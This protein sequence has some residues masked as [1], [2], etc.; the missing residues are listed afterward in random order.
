MSTESGTVKVTTLKRV[1]LKSALKSP[2]GKV[3][4]RWD[5]IAGERGYQ[6]S[7]LTKK[8]GAKAVKTYRTAKEDSILISAEKGTGYYYKVRAYQVVDGKMI[9]APW[10]KAKYCKLR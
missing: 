3:T 5:N 7:K 9:Y 1:N 6:I 4:L 8:D 10:S 2:N